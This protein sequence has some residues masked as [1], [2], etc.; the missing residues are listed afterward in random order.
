MIYA[1]IAAGQKLHIAYEPG[2]GPDAAHLVPAG[3]LGK[4]LCGRPLDSYRMTINVP[5]ANACRN[6]LRVYAARH[7]KE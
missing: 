7:G 3:H 2:E 5:L 4:P 6:C 1:Q